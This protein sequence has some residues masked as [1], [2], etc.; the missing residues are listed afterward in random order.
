MN[1]KSTDIKGKKNR[2]AARD[3]KFKGNPSQNTGNE[4]GFYEACFKATE[5]NLSQLVVAASTN[6]GVKEK[7]RV[8]LYV[9]L[10]ASLEEIANSAVKGPDSSLFTTIPR[11]IIDSGAS[12]SF[13]T[14]RKA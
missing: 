8:S 9:Q 7:A 5:A 13:V 2:K 6:N 12:T 1:R 3:E 10:R 11:N 14:D 4:Y